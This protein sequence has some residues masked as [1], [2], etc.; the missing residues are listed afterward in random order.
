[1]SIVADIRARFDRI[2]SETRKAACYLAVSRAIYRV[3]NFARR[4][5]DSDLEYAMH[6]SRDSSHMAFVTTLAATYQRKKGL[7]TIPSL[8]SDLKES[9]VRHAIARDRGVTRSIVDADALRAERT[10]SRIL[11][12]PISKGLK[13]LRDNVVAHHGRDDGHHGSTQGP[14]NRLMIRTV[15][16]VDQIGMAINGE[17]TATVAVVREVLQQAIALWSL[18]I[19]GDPN[20]NLKGW[21]ASGSGDN[22]R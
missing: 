19:D 6:Y 3:P 4:W 1:M 21:F 17:P 10:I 11:K 2:E 5:A 20:G 16:L 8:M 7:I 22:A 12:L 9:S 18:G 14:L 15:V 13:A